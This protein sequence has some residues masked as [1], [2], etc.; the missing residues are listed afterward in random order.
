[1]LIVDEEKKAEEKGTITIL[2]DVDEVFSPTV[3]M[4]S[5][6]SM[7]KKANK[8]KLTT[9][10]NLTK[11]VKKQ[12]VFTTDIQAPTKTSANEV[13]SLPYVARNNDNGNNHS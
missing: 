4:F 11:K 10:P 1:M 9:V 3:I 2:E 13:R 8:N 5:H 6:S 12:L 7:R